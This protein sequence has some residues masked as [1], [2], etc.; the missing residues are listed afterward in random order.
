MQEIKISETLDYLTFAPGVRLHWSEVRQ[1]YWL[2][3]PEAALALNS[4]AAAILA[5]CD[6]DRSLD[7]IVA[8]LKQQYCDVNVSDVEKLLLSVFKRGLLIRSKV[9]G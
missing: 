1:Q 4:T 5:K 3:F 9:K 8:V 7:E 2:L 6:G